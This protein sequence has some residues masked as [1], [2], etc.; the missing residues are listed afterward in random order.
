MPTFTYT[1][2]DQSGN[3]TRGHL[4]AES[5]PMAVAVLQDQG[6]WITDLR[7]AGGA[8]PRPSG[9]PAETGTVR[10]MWS[11]VSRKDL[12]LF[13]HQLYTLLNAGS[14]LYG[15]LEM[16]SQPNQTPNRNLR[17]VVLALSQDVLTG[18][19]L[20]DSMMR[21]PWLFDRT[22][23][24]MVQAGEHGGLLVDV[25]RRLAEFLER[26]YEL[27]L[28]IKRRTLYP[29]ILLG[30]LILIPSVPTLVLVGF[31]AFLA[32]VW[33]K[34]SLLAM[35]VIPILL[36]GRFLLTTQGGRNA[37]DRLKL[38]IPVVG[39]LTRKLTIARFSRTL[40]ALYGAG[41]PINS[42]TSLAAETCGNYVLESATSRVIVAI[43]R[44]TP[45]SQALAA[46]HFFPPMYL[47]MIQTGETSGS[48]DDILNKAAEFYEEEAKHA[49]IQLTVI[50][51]VALLLIMAVIIAVKIISFYT[52]YV[53]GMMNQG[54]ATGE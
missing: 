37:Y 6:L 43:E 20:S 2:R 35:I 38:L 18:K 45:V 30:A 48:L 3:V 26:E 14:A 49:T 10:A 47:G 24:R 34:V 52:G 7:A 33:G 29:K 28:E 13:Y 1:A 31:G 16:L 41:V 51:G 53:G 27:R 17:R 54:G 11:G 22:Q 39:G 25:L 4:E 46:T 21:F 9:P 44:G 42:A 36:A 15:A 19:R 12:S 23:V 40:A 32:E 50:L 5:Q 8:A